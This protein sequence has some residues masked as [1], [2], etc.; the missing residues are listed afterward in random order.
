MASGVGLY[1]ASVIFTGQKRIGHRY[2]ENGV[3]REERQ[4]GKQ[5]EV[6]PLRPEILVQRSDYVTR[7]G[8]KHIVSPPGRTTW[9]CLAA[10]NP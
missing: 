2:G 4:R 10:T 9:L 7:N 1:R 5:P 8:T 6:L 3:I